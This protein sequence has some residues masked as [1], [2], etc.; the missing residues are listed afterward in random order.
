[1][2]DDVIPDVRGR[3][4]FLIDDGLATGYS[5]IAAGRMVKDLQPRSLVLGIPV[6]PEG[7]LRTVA[8]Y[9]DEVYCLIAQE[10]PPFAVASYY[11]DFHDMSDNEVR[12]ILRRASGTGEE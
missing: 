8:P 9:F 4:V 1:M 12:R 2:G 7:S 11:Q 6:S 10:Y 5:A 3:D